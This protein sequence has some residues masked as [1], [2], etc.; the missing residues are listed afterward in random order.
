MNKKLKV[1]E[2]HPIITKQQALDLHNDNCVCKTPYIIEKPH[3]RLEETSI[4]SKQFFSQKTWC[5]LSCKW[6]SELITTR[7]V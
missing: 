2:T 6:E 4:L 5:C 1:G 7:T 3:C